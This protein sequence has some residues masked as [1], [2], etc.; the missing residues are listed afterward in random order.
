MKRRSRALLARGLDLGNAVHAIYGLY[1]DP[2]SAQ[3]AFDGV[4]AAKVEEH[5]IVVL[6]SEPF[7]DYEFGQRDRR[8][9]MPW[10][11]ALGGL[12]CGASALAFVAFT[13][14]TYPLSTGGMPIV[15]FWPDGIIAYEFTMM[16]AVLATLI[17]LILTAR[18]PR[19]SAQIYD[20]EVSNGKILIGAVNPAEGLRGAVEQ[21][22]R[23]A[24][25]ES[26]VS[27]P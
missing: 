24:G 8:T 14:R 4:R 5:N 7:E 21:A 2:E 11:A 15:A 12:V 26:V 23:K 10:L 27:R 3:R 22:L 19:E 17:T 1:L 16:G 20:P 6:S 18:S 25:T 13:Q 9:L